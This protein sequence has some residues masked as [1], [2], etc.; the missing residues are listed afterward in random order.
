MKWYDMRLDELF[1]RLIGYFPPPHIQGAT[2]PTTSG[3]NVKTIVE[4]DWAEL[5]KSFAHA[6][7]DEQAAFL[8]NAATELR[9]LPGV[10]DMQLLAIAEAVTENAWPINLPIIEDFL[11]TIN[12][13]ITRRP[14]V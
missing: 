7:S 2:V 5:G 4:I 1:L 8:E 10:P 6:D 3:I 14:H 11:D 12:K 13:H 9:S